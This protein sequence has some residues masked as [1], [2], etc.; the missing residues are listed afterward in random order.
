VG[1]PV[2]S[3]E[4]AQAFCSAFHHPTSQTS[5]RSLRCAKVCVVSVHLSRKLSSSPIRNDV[6]TQNSLKF[7][8]VNNVLC[9][10]PWKTCQ[11]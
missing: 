7:P 11:S 4:A 10:Q 9:A 5:A 8:N 2:V 6:F 1:Y 3:S